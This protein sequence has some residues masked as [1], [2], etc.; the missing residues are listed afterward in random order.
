MGHAYQFIFLFFLF[1]P[2]VQAASRQRWQWLPL[3]SGGGKRRAPIGIGTSAAP[4]M[5]GAQRPPLA[6]LLTALLVGWCSLPLPC[7]CYDGA[8]R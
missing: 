2:S 8:N 6:R 7:V 1:I 5:V 4:D 3:A